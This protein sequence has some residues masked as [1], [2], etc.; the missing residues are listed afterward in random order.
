[1][2]GC[3]LADERGWG[4]R[5]RWDGDGL[6]GAVVVSE[7]VR[8]GCEGQMGIVVLPQSTWCG[9]LFVLAPCAMFA[10]LSLRISVLYS[11]GCR[12]S[13]FEGFFQVFS[14]VCFSG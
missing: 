2:V 11:G 9:L 7:G 12:D 5:D 14:R 6:L 1:M 4:P 8:L 13:G 3:W 10:R